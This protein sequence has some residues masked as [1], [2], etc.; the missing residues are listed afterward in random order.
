MSFFFLPPS[1][2]SFLSF[3]FV[4]L[5]HYFF[6]CHL[7]N[8]FFFIHHHCSINVHLHQLSTPLAMLHQFFPPLD[9][10]LIIC[11]AHNL[12]SIR[13]HR[14][15]QIVAPYLCLLLIDVI[16]TKKIGNIT[17]VVPKI[18]TKWTNNYNVIFIEWMCMIF[19]NT[20][21][22]PPLPLIQ[23]CMNYLTSYF[24]Q[25]TLGINSLQIHSHEPIG[26]TTAFP[27]HHGTHCQQ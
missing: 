27:T 4:F 13:S 5:L 26:L 14:T 12:T 1:F 3:P 22:S 8:T 7:N 21:T 25:I 20:S 6:S 15:H 17:T 2:P 19:P 23:L 9:L 16:V 10:H 18:I 11:I 24:N